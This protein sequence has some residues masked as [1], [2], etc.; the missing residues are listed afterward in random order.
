MASLGYQYVFKTTAAIVAAIGSSQTISPTPV[1]VPLVVP[2]PVVSYTQTISP[3][4]V[5]VPIVIPT[6]TVSTESLST[7]RTWKPAWEGAWV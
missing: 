4:A 3:S 5:A 7:T 2:A 1:T 6:P